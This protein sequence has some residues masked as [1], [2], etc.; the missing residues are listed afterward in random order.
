[1]DLIPGVIPRTSVRAPPSFESTKVLIRD[2]P[3][4]SNPSDGPKALM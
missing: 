1:V 4:F 2:G 3:H